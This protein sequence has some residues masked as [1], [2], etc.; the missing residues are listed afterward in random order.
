MQKD[1]EIQNKIIENRNKTCFD[2][3]YIDNFWH[4]G[5]DYIRSSSSGYSTNDLSLI[6]TNL[7]ITL[8]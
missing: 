4:N 5:V 8:I 1:L 3:K 6:I 7:Q 2:G